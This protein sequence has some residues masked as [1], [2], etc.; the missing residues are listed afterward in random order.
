MNDLNTNIIKVSGK[1]IEYFFQNL[2][3]NDINKLN[4]SS[5][6]YTALLSPQG[7]FLNDFFIIKINSN[8]L[9]ECNVSSTE[10]LISELKKYNIRNDINFDLSKQYIT[11]VI[12]KKEL[13]KSSLKKILKNKTFQDEGF[14]CFEDPR[15]EDFLVRFIFEKKNYN[16]TN[17]P[18]SSLSEIEIERI[19]LKIPNSEKDLEI[20][21]SFILNYNFAKINA[22]SF[23]KGCFIGQENTARQNYRGTQKYSLETIKLIHGNFPNINE[24]IFCEQKKIGTMKSFEMNFGL[25]LIRNDE[26]IKNL[27][28]ITTDKNSIFLVS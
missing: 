3:T 1:N 16:H 18:F 8:Y 23:T 6:L 15:N 13:E 11:K 9:I 22:I 10:S 7:K 12:L 17:Y 19:K 24:D 26:K 14:I 21:K 2:I 27:K 25:C 20:N 4:T 5:A 28:K